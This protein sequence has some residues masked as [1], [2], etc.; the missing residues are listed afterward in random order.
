MS[1]NH[2][3]KG[4]IAWM[5]GNAVAANLIMLFCLVGGLFMLNLVKQEVFPEIEHDLIIVSVG[6]PGSSPEEIERGIILSVEDAVSGLDGIKEVTSTASEGSGQ[7]MVELIEGTDRQKLLQ[8]VK[9]EVDRITT[10]PENAKTPQIY[11]A[12]R[13]RHVISLI[14]Y[15]DIKEK[16]LHELAE[17]VRDRLL[18]NRD[19]TQI[20]FSG[21]KELEIS[22]EVSQKNL[23][24]Y[25]LSLSD[26]SEK[27]RTK[28][29]ELPGGGIKT[30]GGEVLLRVKERRDFGRE[31]ARTPIITT[32][33]G[34]VIYLEDIATVKDG[35]ED[36]DMYALYNGKPSIKVNVYAVESQTPIQVAR[37]VK[38]QLGDINASLPPG[39][40]LDIRH[41]RSKV[42]EQRMDLLL[43]N[44]AIG[45]LLVLFI[46]GLFLEIRLAFWVMMGIPISFV[47]SL[48]FLPTL[49]VSINMITLFAYIIALGIVVDDAIVIGEN[50]Y[51]YRQAGNTVL[52][53]SILGA[54]ELAAPVTFSIL[55]N[56]VTFM[57]LYFIPGMMGKIFGAIPVIV[58]TVFLISLFESLFVLPAHLGHSKPVERKGLRKKFHMVQSAF[59]HGFRGWV[60]RRF[61]P[62][63]KYSLNH[64]YLTLIITL[65][66]LLVTLSYAVS[67]RM[68]F[69]LFPRAESDYSVVTASLPYGT[70]IEK[71]TEVMKKIAAGAEKTIK[72]I[73]SDELVRG[74][75]TEVGNGG[76]HNITMRVYLADPEVREKII[77]TEG[78]TVKWR[79]NTGEIAGVDYI[80][81]QSD[82]GGPGSG[83]SVTVE[84]QHRK[85]DV[86]EKASKYLADELKKYPIVKDVDDG[87]QSGKEQ[88][89]FRIKPEAESLG[90]SAAYIAAEIRNAFYG[91]EVLRQQRGRNEV[92]VMVRLPK[93]ERISEYSLSNLIIKTPSGGEAY[94][95]DV[96]EFKR[97]R[98]YTVVNRRNGRRVINV[99]ADVTPRDR[100]NEIVSDLGSNVL[101]QLISRFPGLT[102]SFE[103]HQA[104]IR[105]SL[106]SLTVGFGIAMLAIFA[107]LAIPFKSYSQPLI[108]MVSIPFGITGAILGHLLTGY[109]L[110]LMSM[111]GIVALSGVV[112]NDTLVLVDMANRYI[113]NAGM[114]IKDA[115]Y[116]AA[117]QRFRPIVLTTLTTF[118]GLT[119][120]ILET[121]RQA[122]FMIPMAVSL[123][124]GILFA[125][126]ITLVLVPSLY[127]ILEDI[128]GLRKS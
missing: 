19:I 63:L 6:Y 102:Y 52:D 41:D 122:K 22:I 82:F 79:K 65:G 98:A 75:F 39:V 96:V 71:T 36:S 125:T 121:S 100:S 51:H 21:V 15:G 48:L 111:F 73:G 84:L 74:I 37:A 88:I 23:R 119:P 120:M 76:S 101:P 47:G 61:G 24:K 44:G 43:K 126:I 17:S 49:G 86:L 128:K 16:V 18:Q 38:E 105:D 26:I 46:L 123:G 69:S 32:A 5:A 34:S 90:F 104:E 8:D 58:I 59:S 33:D 110:S 4:P 70:P 92:T 89:D 108:V 95:R 113:R 77:G 62:F 103:G 68:G 106:N 30:K 83:S 116:N 28:S 9:S 114:G 97:G 29:V 72:E 81:F 91:A 60:E 94:L 3:H 45:L 85:I 112:V 124:F 87:F 127:L 42:F 10:F 27:L 115:I 1:S 55:T 40:K 117:I 53:A 99:A 20:D 57:P 54:K 2:K 93:K 14:L 64:R 109:S 118:L 50:I 80:K 31:F 107:L 56:I 78:F 67:G 11:L 25:N 13:K 66:C 12:S 7:V 35:Y